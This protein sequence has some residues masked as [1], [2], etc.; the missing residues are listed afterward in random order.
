MSKNQKLYEAKEDLSNFCFNKPLTDDGSTCPTW[1]K[2]WEEVLTLTEDSTV[3]LSTTKSIVEEKCDQFKE[4]R[5]NCAP[6][7]STLTECGVIDSALDKCVDQ[8]QRECNDGSNVLSLEKIFEIS[9]Q[10]GQLAMPVV[11][12]SN[13]KK[14]QTITEKNQPIESSSISRICETNKKYGPIQTRTKTLQDL[15]I[16]DDTQSLTDIEPYV[17]DPEK[18]R[19]LTERLKN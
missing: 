18:Q 16:S 13:D 11:L 6:L 17:K 8:C 2:G 3:H 1:R 10:D 12:N 5:D 7:I 14:F 4:A 9:S 15:K 19:V